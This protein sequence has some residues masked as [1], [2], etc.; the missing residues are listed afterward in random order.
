MTDEIPEQY[1]LMCS[2]CRTPCTGPDAHVLPTWNAG[3]EQVNTTYRCGNCWL[4][5]L[6][7][8]RETL[9]AGA[10]EVRAGFCDFLE[11]HRFRQDAARLRTQSA[12]EQ[13]PI[14]GLL[15][16]ALADGRLV[17]DP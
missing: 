15:L 7:E 9:M 5:S 3:M 1:S 16:D 4:G 14:F 8:F 17:L 10:P 2:K 13:L 12:E 11:R 6:A